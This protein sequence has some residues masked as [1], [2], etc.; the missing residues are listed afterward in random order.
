MHGLI[1][2]VYFRLLAKPLVYWREIGREW[3]FAHASLLSLLMHV[4]VC[5]F[6]IVC[7]LVTNTGELCC[8]LFSQ[9]FLPSILHRR[10]L[11][12]YGFVVGMLHMKW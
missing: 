2:K 7:T 11:L 9:D 4:F 3:Q 1:L 12:L 8:F 6:S 5:L 10:A